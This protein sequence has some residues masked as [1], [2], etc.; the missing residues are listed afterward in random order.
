[1]RSIDIARTA[2]DLS[3]VADEL[4]EL[5]ESLKR[6]DPET[7]E[8]VDGIMRHA[9]ANGFYGYVDEELLR[10]HLGDDSAVSRAL[11]MMLPRRPI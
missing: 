2:R 10:Q 4:E 8:A 6:D 3:D 5:I 7:W 1:M 9:Q 11:P